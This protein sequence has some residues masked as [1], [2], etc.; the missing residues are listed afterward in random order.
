MSS[1]TEVHRYAMKL[2]EAATAAQV[3]GENDR[4]DA[5]LRQAFSQESAAAQLM[6]ENFDLE[7][8]RSVLYRSAASLAMDCREY[9]EAERLIA[10]ALMGY[11]PIEIAAERRNLLEQLYHE[12][13][14][15][16]FVAERGNRESDNAA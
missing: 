14:S 4:A 13:S 16:L 8:T 2:A 11:P 15:E 5:L 3:R 1:V 6:S 10:A 12:S 9:R 7:P